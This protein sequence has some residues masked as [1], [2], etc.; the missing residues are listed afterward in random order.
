M[1][2]AVHAQLL[3]EVRRDLASLRQKIEEL[4]TVERYLAEKAGKAE[5]SDEEDEP[6]ANGA[7][8]GASSPSAVS[9]PP[10]MYTTMRDAAITVLRRSRGTPQAT[11]DVA[12]AL[13]AG[14]YPTKNP[15]GFRNSV[16]SMMRKDG[17]TFRRVGA[18]EWVLVE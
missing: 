13:L 6:S 5:P 1:K 12:S 18:G 16:F 7:A 15:K 17:N 8:E 14:G 2:Q 11:R 9:D 10:F 4:R 3:A